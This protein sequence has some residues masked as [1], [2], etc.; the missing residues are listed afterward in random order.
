LQG[1]AA[2]AAGDYMGALAH[3]EPVDEQIHRVGSS[4]AQVCEL[5]LARYEDAARLL[6]RRLAIRPPERDRQ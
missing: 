1:V 2:F 3:L 5:R 4:R 6:R